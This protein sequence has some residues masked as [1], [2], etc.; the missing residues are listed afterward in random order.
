VFEP[1]LSWVQGIEPHRVALVPRPRGGEWLGEEVVGWRTAD[2]GLVLS[3]L[4]PAEVRELELG[5]ERSLCAAEGI[6]FVS[7]P[8]PDRGTPAHVRP[9]IHVRTMER[10]IA[11]ELLAACEQTISSLTAAEE[12]IRRI[13]DADERRHLM[14][15]LAMVVA[16]VLGTIRAPVVLEHPDLVPSVDPGDP[17]TLLDEVEQRAVLAL[18]PADL[19]LIDQ[20]ILS[21][22]ASSWRKV[23]RIVGTALG[24][25]QGR[26][27]GVPDSYY[28]QRVALLVEAG[29]LESQG[30]LQHMRF[31]E[32]RLPSVSGAA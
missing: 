5:A 1:S 20:M 2:I 25:L 8:I 15:S 27:P 9:H 24:E 19:E 13:Q 12:A 21:K 17:D 30:N 22:C 26:L 28:A 4:E 7:F 18:S 32:V 14:R 16:D 23:A 31:S 10:E 29:S 6:Q 11:R 3:L